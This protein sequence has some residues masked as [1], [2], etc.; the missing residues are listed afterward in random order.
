ML[1]LVVA[2][3]MGELERAGVESDGA[4]NAEEEAKKKP[5]VDTSKAEDKAGD[6]VTD[7]VA[8]KEESPL[9]TPSPLSGGGE[10]SSVGL[11]GEDGPSVKLDSRVKLEPLEKIPVPARP[12]SPAAPRVFEPFAPETIAHDEPEE[13]VHEAAANSEASP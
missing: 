1:N 4:E 7:F 5:S 2:T 12:L 3:L 11:V 8:E 9:A 13:V 6:V 10:L